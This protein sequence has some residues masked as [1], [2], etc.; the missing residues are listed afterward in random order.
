MKKRKKITTADK[1]SITEGIRLNKYLSD[2]GICSRREA[3]RMIEAG[4]VKINNEIAGTGQR[5]FPGQTVYVRGKKI[6]SSRPLI[7]IALNKPS[8]VEC[9]SNANVKNNIMDLVHFNEHIFPVG[10]LDKE[11]EGLI[12]MTNDGGLVNKINR[13]G[14]NHEKEYIVKVNRPIT[15]TFIDGLS[16]GVPILDTVTRPCTVNP[17]DKFTFRIILT[18]GLNRQIRRM[19]EHFGY[20]VISLKR[21]R[22]MNIQLG[23]LRSGCWRNVTGGELA[24]LEKQLTGS[25]DGPLEDPEYGKGKYHG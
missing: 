25:K 14:N 18:Q 21:I 3:D 7:L 2:A 8:G 6:Q 4:M 1:D 17:I 11:S 5:V 22:I 9:T 12:L 19:C 13:F 23:H 20:K 10:R 24:R 16:S 15:K